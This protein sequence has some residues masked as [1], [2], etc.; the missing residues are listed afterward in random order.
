MT[1]PRSTLPEQ[2]E[3]ILPEVTEKKESG[4]PEAESA[5]EVAAKELPIPAPE[6]ENEIQAEQKYAPPTQTDSIPVQPTQHS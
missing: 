3:L 6:I 5:L 2:E 4:M 1:T